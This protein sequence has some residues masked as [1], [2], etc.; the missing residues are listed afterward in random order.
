MLYHKI[1]IHLYTTGIPLGVFGKLHNSGYSFNIAR[2]GDRF[3]TAE[4]CLVHEHEVVEKTRS[5]F[6]RWIGSSGLAC[7][8]SFESGPSNP[9]PDALCPGGP[10]A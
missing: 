9:A 1:L 10:D 2:V 4:G 5:P 8:V 6:D 3:E 7:D